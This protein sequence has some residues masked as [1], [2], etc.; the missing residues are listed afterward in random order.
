[1]IQSLVCAGR[2]FSADISGLDEHNPTSVYPAHRHGVPALNFKYLYCTERFRSELIRSDPGTGYA[3]NHGM[4][5][6]IDNLKG[7]IE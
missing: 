4:D 6:T 3:V 1:M 2:P 5:G 7:R